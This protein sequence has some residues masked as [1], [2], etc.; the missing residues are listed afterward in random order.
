MKKIFSSLFV[1]ALVIS[2]ILVGAQDT[3]IEGDVNSIEGVKTKIELAASW[4]QY[5][6]W[7]VAV[8]FI[9]MA[10]FNYLTSGGNAEKAGKAKS[11]ITGAVIAIVIALLATGL[12]TIVGNFLGAP[13]LGQ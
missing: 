6:L 2:P 5:L 11:Q 3:L 4:L 7:A 13:N 1:L 10:A 9:I 12:V 8:V